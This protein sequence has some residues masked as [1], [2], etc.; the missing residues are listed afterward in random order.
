MLRPLKPGDRITMGD[1][2]SI[3]KPTPPY[4]GVIGKFIPDSE[5][6][7]LR[8]PEPPAKAPNV[9]LI[10]LD[11][12]GF[13]SCSTFGGPVPTPTVDKVAEAGLRYNQFHT[14]A[15]CSPTRAAK[16]LGKFWCS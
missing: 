3:P 16:S 9:V 11:D 5:P 10:M 1:G 4:E 12:V 7:V 6:V 13:G 8:S 2:T 14:T 15:L